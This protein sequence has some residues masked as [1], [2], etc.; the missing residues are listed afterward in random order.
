MVFDSF[1]VHDPAN[2]RVQILTQHLSG[3]T[4]A[5]QVHWYRDALQAQAPF[6]TVPVF[7]KEMFGIKPH[8]SERTAKMTRWDKG[9]G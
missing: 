4:V 1:L 7:D 2:W 8:L 9:C 3:I 6:A 5:A